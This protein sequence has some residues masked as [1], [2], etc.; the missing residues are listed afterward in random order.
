MKAIQARQ[1]ARYHDIEA[2]LPGVRNSTLAETLHALEAA[3]LIDH[4]GPAD[5]V[6]RIAYTLTASG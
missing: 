5:T 4:R 3:R 1:P 2:A 6:P